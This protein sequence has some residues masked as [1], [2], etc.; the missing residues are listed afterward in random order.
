MGKAQV[1]ISAQMGQTTEYLGK[2]LGGELQLKLTPNRVDDG[3]SP[4]VPF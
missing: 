3:T 2:A 4:A 1:R